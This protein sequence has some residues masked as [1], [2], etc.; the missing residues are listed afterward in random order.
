MRFDESRAHF[1]TTGGA[2]AEVA[3][4]RFLEAVT[5]VLVRRCSFRDVVDS[6]LDIVILFF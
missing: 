1:L 6:R 5:E 3:H 2:E 4:I